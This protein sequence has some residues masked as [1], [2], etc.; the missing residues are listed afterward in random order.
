[1]TFIGRRGD[2]AAFSEYDECPEWIAALNDG[3]YDYLVTTPAY[4]Q[5]NPE[6]AT[7]PVEFLWISNAPEVRQITPPPT[8][9]PLESP[10]PG[11][12]GPPLVDVWE[13]LGAID[14]ATCEGAPPRGAPTP[15]LPAD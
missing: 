6:S 13:I 2:R 1:M 10:D 11:Y 5:D 15:G 3:G 7:Q 12:S 8:E 9:R 4:D 14:P